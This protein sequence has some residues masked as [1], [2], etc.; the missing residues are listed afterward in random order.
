MGA[1]ARGGRMLD[2]NVWP[3]T[4]SA[5]LA[6]ITVRNSRSREPAPKPVA[7]ASVAPTGEPDRPPP[8]G[9]AMQVFDMSGGERS[10]E[11]GMQH[12]SLLDS[13]REF[14]LRVF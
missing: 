7:P 12:L 11:S 14:A 9:R 2:N 1:F 4:T 6:A 5:M 3:T 13:E 8:S 10:N